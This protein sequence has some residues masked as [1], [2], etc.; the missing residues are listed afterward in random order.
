MTRLSFR[1]TAL[2][3]IF[4][5]VSLVM[6][7]VNAQQ[8]TTVTPTLGPTKTATPTPM[9]TPT[10]LATLEVTETNIQQNLELNQSDLSVLTGNVQRPNGMVWFDDHLY[11]S[12]TGDWTIYN[13]DATTGQTRTYVAGVR[14]A[15]MLHAEQEDSEVVLWAPDYQTNHLL[16]L[17]RMGVEIVGEDLNG[18]WGLLALDEEQFLISNLLGNNVVVIDREGVQRPV[19]ENLIAPTGLAVD[20]ERIY[21]ANN[22]STRRA[23]EWYDRTAAVEGTEALGDAQPLVTG[24]Q[25]TTGLA[26]GA[27]GY[28][29]FA[30]ALGTRGVVGRVLPGDCANGGCTADQ[31]E[32]VLLTELASP[33]AGLTISPDMRLF[34][35]TMF[36][37]DIYWVQLPA[38]D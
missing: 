18:P 37:P 29:Y 16:R 11:A 34:V 9:F 30:Y 13:L 33:L 7:V 26:M 36:S 1:S 12:C 31:V 27:D 21:V 4:C 22:G 5:L 20:E 3:A 38:T 19:I 28:L 25:N 2:I 23:I 14:N 24:L 10:E 6:T 32:V 17:T 15:H 8:E 35:H